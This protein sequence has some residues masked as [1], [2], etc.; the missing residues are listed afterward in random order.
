MTLFNCAHWVK[1]STSYTYVASNCT[2]RHQVPRTAWRK[3]S[4]S[5]TTT[6]VKP[7]TM[8]L[9]HARS[10]FDARAIVA[11]TSVI[12][13]AVWRES[14][15]SADSVT[16]CGRFQSFQEHV[17]FSA[18]TASIISSHVCGEH[19]FTQSHVD[20]TESVSATRGP[21]PPGSR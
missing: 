17:S 21:S 19:V 7:T 16:I 14:L 1:S 10:H 4:P 9:F 12:V 2:S 13:S 5:R 8:L 11:P 6:R 3:L 20:N 15:L 18:N